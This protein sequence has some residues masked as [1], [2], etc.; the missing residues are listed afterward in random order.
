ML[1]GF[2][3]HLGDGGS[4]QGGRRGGG[5]SDWLALDLTLRYSQQCFLV[6]WTWVRE[7]TGVKDDTKDSA[8]SN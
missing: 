8:Q 4:D 5:R 2:C 7:K 1:L 6:D 3:S